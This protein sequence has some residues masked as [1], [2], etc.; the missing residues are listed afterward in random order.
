MDLTLGIFVVLAAVAI[1]AIA[2]GAIG[3]E[4]HR[5]DAIAPRAVYT[6]DEAV[7]F[8][9]D[10]I[11]ERSQ[12]RLTPAEVESLLIAHI[13]WLHAQGLAPDRVID[14]RQNIDST[15]I[16]S[17]EALIAHL[18]MVATDTGIEV[19]DDVDIVEV[20]DGHLSYFDAIGAVGPTAPPDDV[21]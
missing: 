21:I 11:P 13:N 7:D 12:A 17:D 18:M 6:L 1:F 3:R 14:Q 2:A 20:V 5:L 4:A 9:A 19:L 16:V 10:Q 15:L 8:V